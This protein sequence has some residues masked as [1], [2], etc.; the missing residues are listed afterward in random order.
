M[1]IG[2]LDVGLWRKPDGSISWKNGPEYMKAICNCRIW[3]L[4]PICVTWLVDDE[5]R[6]F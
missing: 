3:T 6:K 5:C 4:G 1:R 2:R